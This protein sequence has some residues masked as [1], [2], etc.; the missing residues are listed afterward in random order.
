MNDNRS[1][2]RCLALLQCFRNGPRQS[3][4]AL[5]K[6]AE[7]PHSTAL[8]FLSTLE[9][10]GYVRK[11]GAL[12][13][14]TPQMLEIGFAALQNTGVTEVIQQ[15]LQNLADR[16]SG[17]INIGEEGKGEVVVIARAVAISELKKIFII[18]LR[19]GNALPATS[20]LYRA[21]DLPEDA[22][23][24]VPYPERKL[25]TVAIPLFRGSARHLS[26][27]LSVDIDDYP[28]KRIEGELVP[29]LQAERGHIRQ[30]MR[31]SEVSI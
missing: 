26:L 29:V 22:W 3:L 18:N 2:L 21:L 25:A 6:A 5:S 23:V 9:N 24:V 16:F 19:V 11:E 1:V 30:L 28:A 13:S 10:A 12:W 4:T 14:L 27:G 31:L 8:R 7:L 20:A 15:A 17:M